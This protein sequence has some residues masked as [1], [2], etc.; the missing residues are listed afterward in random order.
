MKQEQFIQKTAGLDI[1]KTKL[2]AAIAG[3]LDQLCVTN[4]AVGRQALIVWLTQH[5]VHRVGMEATGGY[6]R[7]IREALEIDGFDV[8]I[9]RPEEVRC[10]AVF[11]RLKAKN[12]RLDAQIIAQ[13]TVQVSG[14]RAS[15]D[16]QLLE[17][18]EHLTQY[19]QFSDLL[20]RAKMFKEHLRLKESKAENAVLISCLKGHKARVVARILKLIKAC[21]ELKAR[22]D[23]LRS[24]PGI[25]PVIAAVLVIRMP[26]LGHMQHGQASALLGVAPYDRDSGDHKG[27]RFI[28]GG[29]S[30]PRRFLYIAALAAKRM[31]TPFK[32]L[33]DRLRANAKPPKVAIVAVMRKLIEAANLV[34]KR[35]TP[36]QIQLN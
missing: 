19:E 10:F 8:I 22:Y 12:D 1:G 18:A 28:K 15:R 6:E 24:L 20:A 27:K 4:D 36:W 16:P 21:P 23:L 11:K 13:A 30:R 26:E 34:L 17:L 3:Q 2:D 29:R 31:N 25:G 35:H 5:G 9:H 32:T 7:D 33:A 14:I